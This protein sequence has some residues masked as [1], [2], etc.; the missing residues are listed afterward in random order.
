MSLGRRLL[1]PLAVAALCAIA[2]P[3][4]AAAAAP[5]AWSSERVA[6]QRGTYDVS[7]SI[8]RP[9]H[10]PRQRVRL[11]VEHARPRTVVLDPSRRPRH[12]AVAIR[13]NVLDGRL[14]VRVDARSRDPRLRGWHPGVRATLHRITPRRS[15]SNAVQAPASPASGTLPVS[16]PVSAPP[17]PAAPPPA[18]DQ[19][20]AQ[21]PVPDRLVWSDEFDGAAGTSP[22]PSRWDAMEGGGGWGNNELE[23]YTGRPQNVSLDGNG[24]LAITARQETYSGPDHIQ[25]AYTSARIQTKGHF[26]FT[27][28]RL[29]ARIRIPAGRGLWPAFWALGDDIDTAGWPNCGEMDVMESL[30]QTPAQISGTLHGPVGTSSTQWGKGAAFNAPS[31]LATG[32]H[33]YGVIW[34]PDTVEWTVDGQAY[35]RV[36]PSDLPA[37]ARWVFDHNFHLLL[38][39]AVGG[40]WPG[41]PDASTSFPAT[42]LVDW[43][44]VYQ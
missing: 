35:S 12:A 13:A 40:D 7:V 17:S 28:G 34:G 31:S 27:Y 30:G 24:T 43:V 33:V 8:G 36:T 32:F 9:P 21:G 22:D 18:P 26:S 37:G 23:S 5:H 11:V 6:V 14:N 1:A 44:R 19:T 39:L 42:M 3:S 38:N 4:A 10:G 2:A 15:R 41:S 20:S 16:A 29:E 25:R